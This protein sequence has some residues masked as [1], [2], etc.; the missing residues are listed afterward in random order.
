MLRPFSFNWPKDQVFG[1]KEKYLSLIDNI[2]FF[3]FKFLNG[4]KSRQA[5]SCSLSLPLAPLSS[6]PFPENTGR[7]SRD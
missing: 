2:F 1:F 3:F 4:S 7:L 6:E 5:P